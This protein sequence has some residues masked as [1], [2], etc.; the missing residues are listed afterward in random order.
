MTP[1]RTSKLRF[2]PLT[3]GALALLL[4]ACT[5]VGNHQAAP[6]AKIDAPAVSAEKAA[7][8]HGVHN[9]VTYA[10]DMIC[11]AVPEGAAGL[12]TLKA[13]G[14]KT[15]VSVDGEVETRRGRQLVAGALVDVDAP[16]GVRRLRVVQE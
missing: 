1:H 4:A 8:L 14:V 16:T 9:V 7:D 13:M 12:A 11:G 10:P 6:V 2:L 3:G 5:E 15:I